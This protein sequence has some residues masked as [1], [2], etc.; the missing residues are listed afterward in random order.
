MIKDDP[1]GRAKP[2]VGPSTENTLA[3]FPVVIATTYTIR[4]IFFF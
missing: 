3:F 4:C 1:S 2:K